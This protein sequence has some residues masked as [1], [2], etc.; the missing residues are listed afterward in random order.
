MSILSEKQNPNVIDTKV[1][2]EIKKNV[3]GFPEV[4]CES[5]TL[6]FKVF[7]ENVSKKLLFVPELILLKRNISV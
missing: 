5:R 3:W 7:Q 6:L 1:E 4:W 2:I